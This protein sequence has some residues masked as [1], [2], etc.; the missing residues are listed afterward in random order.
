MGFWPF[1]KKDKAE[2]EDDGGID[3]TSRV[4]THAIAS[5]AI[6]RGK[7]VIHFEQPVSQGVAE[8]TTVAAV[9]ALERA[10]SAADE[11]AALTGSGVTDRVLAELADVER[12]RSIEL[13][14][15][16]IVDEAA[17]GSRAEPIP[18]SR[19]VAPAPAPPASTPP[20]RAGSVPP[21]E[22]AGSLPPPPKFSS[23]PPRRL[24]S[25][26]PPRFDS[27]PPPRFDSATPPKL[28][29]VPPPKLDSAPPPKLSSAP[30]P[31]LGSVPPPSMASRIA[32]RPFPY[33]IDSAPASVPQSR[34]PSGQMLIARGERLVPHDA[35]PES[36]ADALVPLMRDATTKLALGIL[37][38]YDLTVVR[39]VELDPGDSAMAEAIIPISSAPLGFFAESRR[40]ELQR[41][42]TALGAEAYGGLDSE[43]ATMIAFL[44]YD[45]LRHVGID[46]PTIAA[47][48]ERMSE[49]AFPDRS[50]AI[51]KLGRYLHPVEGT[52]ANELANGVVRAVGHADALRRLDAML[53]PLLASLQDDVAIAAAQVRSAIPRG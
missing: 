36:A 31:K 16:H 10:M 45:A 52:A 35:T 49:R 30:P 5:G 44:F 17:P 28:S 7:L 47:V 33:E 25:A 38:A 13:V 15:L 8:G 20:P 23:V 24:D 26:P 43:C 46:T 22:E 4:V 14:A 11:L 41:W 2:V 3:Y 51:A 21:V 27:A 39:N 40:D 6:V 19:A 12:P 50:V 42:E 34:K 48:V 29:S 1:G 32:T 9:A 53:T 37:R 18:P